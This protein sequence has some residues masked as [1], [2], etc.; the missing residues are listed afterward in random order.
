[1]PG[2]GGGGGWRGHFYICAYWVCA[3]RETPIFSPKF[4]LAPEH[5]HFYS[6]CRS[7]DHHFHLFHSSRSVAARGRSTAARAEPRGHS[8]L[9]AFH[10]RG[11]SR[12]LHIHARA[13]SGAPILLL[14]RGTYLPKCGA[15]APP[16]RDQMLP[17]PNPR[18]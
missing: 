6:F 2:G 4:P 13:H 10:A 15:S 16:P 3:T 5:H 11:S 14:F 17:K 12:A 1:M 7:G 9:P 8:R 18:I